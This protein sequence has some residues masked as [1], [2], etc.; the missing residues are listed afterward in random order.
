MDAGVRRATIFLFFSNG[1]TAAIRL[2]DAGER[3]SGAG[4]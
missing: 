2:F 1:K 4:K 3:R